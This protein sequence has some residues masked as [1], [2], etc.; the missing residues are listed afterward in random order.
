MV[1]ALFVA[2]GL[3]ALLIKDVVKLEAELRVTLRQ[4]DYVAIF[5]LFRVRAAL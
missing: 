3:R 1:G 5:V 2:L 4:F